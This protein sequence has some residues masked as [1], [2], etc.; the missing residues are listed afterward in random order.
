ML[1]TEHNLRFL[2]GFLNDIRTAI[3]DD[4]FV[5]FKKDFLSRFG[6]KTRG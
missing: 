4:R 6:G 5:A 2:H 3:R 1:A